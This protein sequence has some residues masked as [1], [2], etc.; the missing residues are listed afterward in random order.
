MTTSF[1]DDYEPH[2]GRVATQTIA[3]P[4]PPEYP[5]GAEAK[6]TN[7]FARAGLVLGILPLPLFGAIA[8]ILGIKRA[9]DVKIGM[10][11]SIVGLVL[12]LVWAVGGIV[13]AIVTP[14]VL[15]ASTGGCR[16][17]AQFD[18]DYPATKL[19]ADQAAGAP[20]VADLQA[21]FNTLNRIAQVTHHATVR[22]AAQTEAGDLDIIIQYLRQGAQPDAATLAKQKTDNDVLHETCGSF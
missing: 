6:Q 12:S 21:Y 22:A 3:P 11:M 20:Y 10:R 5:T 15:K 16:M 4:V 13:V 19:A 17:L 18:H 2:S 14:H 7:G 8:S 9:R 1:D